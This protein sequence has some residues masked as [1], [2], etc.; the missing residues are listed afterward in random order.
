[1]DQVYDLYDQA[2]ADRA[3]FFTGKARRRGAGR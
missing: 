2:V 3:A 1:M